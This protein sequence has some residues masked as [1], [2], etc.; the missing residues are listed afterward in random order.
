MKKLNNSFKIYE[1][2]KNLLAG[3]STFGKSI[4][5]FAYGITP[6][7]LEKGE[8]AYVWDVDG[9]KYLD[10]MMSLGALILGYN[11]PK[12]NQAVINQLNKGISFSLSHKLEIE[13]AEMI[14]ERVPSAELV[15]FAKNGNDATT[16]AVR[17]SRYVTG[18]NHVL[19]CG[20]HGWQ[21]WYICQTSMDGGIPSDI[22]NYSHRFQYNDFDSLLNVVDK[23]KGEI[24]CIIMEPVS[25]QETCQNICSKCIDSGNC[26][27]FLNKIRELCNSQNIILIFDEVVT[28]FRFDRGGYQNYSGIIPDLSCFSKAIG[29]GMPLS[30]LAGK[31][32]IM[33]HSTEIFFSLTF[34]GEALSLAAA[35]AVMEC[36]DEENA[37]DEI[38]K[39][40]QYFL[41]Q[42][43]K[44]I[45]KHE[46]DNLIRFEGFPCRSVVIFKDEENNTA[47]DLRTYWIQELSKRNILTAGYHII[48]F[49]HKKNEIDYL[50]T[51]FDE[52]LHDI[53]QRIINNDLAEFLK[54][55][56]AKMSARDI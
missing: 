12:V 38:R 35:K 46:L 32:E 28:G 10:T 8:G 44:I 47:S 17:L 20:Y 16:A 7:S 49:M 1:K 6:F 33:K 36:L 9:N 23:L 40:G 37:F 5:Q 2:S 31:K 55:P 43:E 25:R 11:H 34:A 24:A 48:S 14:C 15:R 42:S 39:C 52:V 22:K 45:Q 18:K 4:D 41:D 19:F 21:D 53:K 29:N 30:V 51:Q 13:V 3:P 54:C 27:G 50:L 56:T 26:L